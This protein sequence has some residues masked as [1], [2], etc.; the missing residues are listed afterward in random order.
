[1]VCFP[2]VRTAVSAGAVVSAAEGVVKRRDGLQ[3]AG[4]E[5]VGSETERAVSIGVSCPGCGTVFTP[6]GR[7]SDT[8]QIGVGL[9]RPDDE[10]WNGAPTGYVRLCRMIW[11]GRNRLSRSGAE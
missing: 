7:T 3:P 1:M 2:T 5:D 4:R 11:G 9:K 10:R 8:A 6:P